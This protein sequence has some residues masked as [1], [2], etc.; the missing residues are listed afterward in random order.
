[1]F[2]VAAAAVKSAQFMSMEQIRHWKNIIHI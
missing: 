2:A 1:M